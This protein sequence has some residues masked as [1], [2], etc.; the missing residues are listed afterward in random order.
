MTGQQMDAWL[1]CLWSA[2]CWNS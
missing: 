2:Q 1:V